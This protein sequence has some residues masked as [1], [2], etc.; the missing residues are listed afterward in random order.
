MNHRLRI[1]FLDL[2]DVGHV[3]GPEPLMGSSFPPSREA[4]FMI[5]HHALASEN[6]MHFV[7]DDLLGEVQSG[8]LERAGIVLDIRIS[9]PNEEESSGQKHAGDIPEP[10]AQQV[11]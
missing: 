4:P 10:E 3:L 2:P 5:A 1:D 8:L 7:P 9:A 6:R 11:I